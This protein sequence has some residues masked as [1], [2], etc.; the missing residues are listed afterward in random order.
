M[1]CLWKAILLKGRIIICG[2]PPVYPLS[3]L[4]YASSFLA[5]HNVKKW[6]KIN[7]QMTN[8]KFFC[9]HYAN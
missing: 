8:P 3:L 7:Q 1:F 2:D 5:R 6:N 4:I 9:Q